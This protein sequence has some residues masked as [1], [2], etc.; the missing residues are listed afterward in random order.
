MVIF[1]ENFIN[2]EWRRTSEFVFTDCLDVTTVVN[3][4]DYI[5]CRAVKDERLIVTEF[6]T[7]SDLRLVVNPEQA[8]VEI[9]QGQHFVGYIEFEADNCEDLFC[10]LSD[11]KFYSLNKNKYELKTSP[12]IKTKG[13]WGGVI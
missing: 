5:L 1:T 10:L 3:N 8:R 12:M 7:K 6:G 4:Y 11:L 9:F 13:F 2:N